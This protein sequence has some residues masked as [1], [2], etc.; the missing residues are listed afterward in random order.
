MAEK[1]T[2]LLGWLRGEA[3]QA[4]VESE[5]APGQD[6]TV[7]PAMPEEQASDRYRDLGEIGR[8][9][10]ASVRR[11]YDRNLLRSVAMKL[12]DPRVADIKGELDR[13]VEE[14]QITG[15]LE[16]PNIPPVHE[17]G[18]DE[19]GTYFF[20]MNYIR[21][22][23]L[24]QVFRTNFSVRSERQLFQALQVFVKACDAVSYAHH[25]GVIHC[26]LKPANL[27]V[28]KHGEVYVMDWGIARL[29]AVT[30]PSGAD[31]QNRAVAVRRGEQERSDEGRVVGSIGYMS[32]EQARGHNAQLDERS[33]VFSLGA[34]LYRALTGRPAYLATSEDELLELAADARW[35]PAQ[36][37][38][39]KDLRLP[40]R[41]CAICE[42][43][44]A[45]APK[46][47]FQTVEALK[48]EIERYLS[49]SGRAPIRVAVPGEVLVKEGEPGSSA[50]VI[51]KGRCVAYKTVDGQRQI[52]REM[53]PGEIFGEMAILTH[54][55]RT[56]TVEAIEPVSVRVLSA[57]ALAQELGQTF[58]I[59]RLIKVLA[60]R[61]QDADAQLT[62][63]HSEKTRRAAQ[64]TVLS[65]LCM[66][67]RQEELAVAPWK[68]LRARLEARHGLGGE[69][70]LDAALE[71]PGVAVDP[72][73]DLITYRE[74]TQ[75][76]TD[77]V[78]ER[79]RTG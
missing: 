25:H 8:G 55:P 72:A 29:R 20:T 7:A 12:I 73:A 52:L 42:K 63:L 36:D 21:G 44:M 38:V 1:N 14:A 71:I 26:D 62:A 4:P 78:N 5:E 64:M 23:T 33:D 48:E 10:F 22:Q 30:R 37:V 69:A 11:V 2:G 24:E 32:P 6:A 75:P 51:E 57:D 76:D 61:F 43:A 68:V 47:R 60:E 3:K 53:G 40:P 15:Q 56:A 27:M 74:P 54:A 9:A 16:H 49:G 77:T 19:T 39:A 41:L 13:F 17:L 66:G 50:Y 46:D 70:A 34:I 45:A 79:P 67:L 58:F 28:G 59:G 65:H 18:I 31:T 35:I